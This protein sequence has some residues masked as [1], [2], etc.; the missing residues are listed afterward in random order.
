MIK[1][2]G[3]VQC[4]YITCMLHIPPGDYI[5]CIRPSIRVGMH[6]NILRLPIYNMLNVIDSKHI[7]LKSY[8]FNLAIAGVEGGEYLKNRY[9][10]R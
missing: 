4:H 10:Y 9:G 3:K 8:L 5:I 2:K 7:Y 1:A 6:L